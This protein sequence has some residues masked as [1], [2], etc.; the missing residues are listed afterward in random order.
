MASSWVSQGPPGTRSRHVRPPSVVETSAPAS[1]ATQSRP[2]SS[3]WHAIHRTWW[4][5]GL[6]GKDQSDEEGNVSKLLVCSQ[7]FPAS[8]ERQ[9]FARFSACPNLVARRRAGSEGH[10]QPAREPDRLPRP[11]AIIAP[12]HAATVGAAPCAPV[13]QVVGYQTS[14]AVANPTRQR[15]CAAL[16]VDDEYLV[17]GGDQY[18]HR[19]TSP[20]IARRHFNVLAHRIDLTGNGIDVTNAPR[21]AVTSPA[22]IA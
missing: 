5:S 21:A 20:W 1:I 17:A 10:D 18:L 4:V 7:E 13:N 22:R 14:G 11:P 12:E 3:G 6:G 19:S 2:G 9:D 8:P 16:G 15:G